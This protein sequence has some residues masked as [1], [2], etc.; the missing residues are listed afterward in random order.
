MES[1]VEVINKLSAT[2]TQMKDDEYLKDGLIYC[3]K[4]N[5][6]RQARINLF[7]QETI[8]KCMCK[9]EKDA[10]IETENK[11]KQL[12]K[13]DRIKALKVNSL[14]G[15]RY[16]N[17]SFDTCIDTN[18]SFVKAKARCK[19]YCEIS[20]T[21]LQKGYGIYIY[22][23]SGTGKTHLTACMCNYLTEKMNQCLFTNFSEIS[24]SIRSTFYNHTNSEENLIKNISNVD[25]LFLDDIG[26]EIMQK[27]GE[28]TWVQEKMYDIINTRYN[29]KRPTIFT[30]N[31]SMN[32]LINN[33]GMMNKTVDR[34][35]E[36]SN[37]VLKLEG[38][39]MRKRANEKIPF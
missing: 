34:I 15:K 12:E 38:K 1:M 11:A 3:K 35:L 6:P 18:E 10:Y 28:D 36:M 29:S 17:V 16:E 24:K 21:V 30:S 13:M 19:K 14:L 26:T 37:A 5:T 23:D 33:R 8:V 32:E 39:S 7:G 31:Y 22:G 27:N 20:A 9:C 2:N 4:C 25:F